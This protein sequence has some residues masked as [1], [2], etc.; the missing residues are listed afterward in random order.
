[1]DGHTLCSGRPPTLPKDGVV[2]TFGEDSM[3]GATTVPRRWNKVTIA[4][5]PAAF[6]DEG[7]DA[8][9]GARD[10]LAWRI[11]DPEYPWNAYTVTAWL[12]GVDVSGSRAEVLRLMA[13]F[14]FTSPVAST[15]PSS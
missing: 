14:R 1:M 6:E 13:S 5:S 10:V 2:I 9:L 8:G 4:G 11:E 3:I 15:T 7:R 12:A